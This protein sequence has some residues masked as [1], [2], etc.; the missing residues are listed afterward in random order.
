MLSTAFVAFC[1]RTNSRGSVTA[2][3]YFDPR[4]TGLGKTDR[5]GLL[6]RASAMDTRS[7]FIDLRFHEFTGLG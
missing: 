2:T 6:G 4:T 5:N 1:L 3:L 7:Y